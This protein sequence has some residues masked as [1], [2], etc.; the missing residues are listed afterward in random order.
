MTVTIGRRELL[1]A[2]GGAAA[3]WP[4]AARAQQRAM[5]VIGLLYSASPAG[6]AFFVT[7][8]R[9]GLKQTGHIEGQ[10]VTVEYRWGEGQPDRLA[11]LA[12]DLIGRQIAVIATDTRGALSLKKLNPPIPVVFISGGDPVKLGLVTSLNQPAGNM[13]GASFLTTAAAAKRLELL[14]ELMPTAT[15]I[16]Y[17]VNPDNFTI[18]TEEVQTA[19]RALGLQILVLN[20]RNEGDFDQAFATLLER[21]ADA[22]FVGGDPFFLTS[23]NRVVA[24]AA[25]H[26]I[27]AI[28]N[29]RQYAQAG[30]LIS[31]GASIE[32]AQRQAGVYVG[33]ILKGAKPAELP[34]VQTDRI[35]LVINLRTAKTLGLKVPLTLQVAADEV[36]E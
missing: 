20:T 12:A 14:R 16:G 13:T 30:G 8:F 25:R 29:L 36:I 11:A 34:V 24:L 1:A 4:L 27:P 2:L 6:M 31:Y 5:P 15:R 3:A 22:L 10:N 35:E 9:N 21:Q 17:L 18:E 7:A 26:A 19:G 23:R 28:Y 33:H 32:D